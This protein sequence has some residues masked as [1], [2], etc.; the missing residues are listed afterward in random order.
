[1]LAGDDIAHLLHDEILGGV[2]HFP[3]PHRSPSCARPVAASMVR[4][5]ARCRSG[6]SRRISAPAVTMQRNDREIGLEDLAETEERGDGHEQHGSP[7]ASA[8]AR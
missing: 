7:V 3:L 4:V 8:K 6:A 1:M 2:R 5:L